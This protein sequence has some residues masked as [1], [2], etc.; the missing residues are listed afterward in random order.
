MKENIVIYE[1]GELI[2]DSLEMSEGFSPLPMKILMFVNVW[3]IR[4]YL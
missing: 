1:E 4:V 3:N 2:Q